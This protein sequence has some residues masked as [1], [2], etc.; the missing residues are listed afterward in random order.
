MSVVVPIATPKEGLAPVSEPST[1]PRDV[2]KKT[3]SKQLWRLMLRRGLTQ[4]ELGRKAGI[5]R[6]LINRYVKG[7][8]LPGEQM[9]HKLAE[10]LDVRVADLYP[11]SIEATLDAEGPAIELRQSLADPSKA[12]LR[13]NMELPYAVALSVLALIQQGGSAAAG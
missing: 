12:H 2:A 6:D 5:G 8:S 9:A 1:G 3:F 4:A 13:I 7:L 10:A 11:A